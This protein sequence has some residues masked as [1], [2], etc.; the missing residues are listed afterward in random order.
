MRTIVLQ[1]IHVKLEII[2]IGLKFIFLKNAS[3]T[4]LDNK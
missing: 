1:Q 3:I 2:N 4:Q